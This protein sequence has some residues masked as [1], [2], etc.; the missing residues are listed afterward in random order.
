MNMCNLLFLALVGNAQCVSQKSLS[1]KKKIDFS[2]S[3]FT[4][5]KK[6]NEKAMKW[7]NTHLDRG[8]K[9]K[10]KKKKKKKKKVHSGVCHVYAHF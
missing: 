7:G 8:K 5:S 6:K 2:L 4:P 9:W 10:K 1:L 3:H